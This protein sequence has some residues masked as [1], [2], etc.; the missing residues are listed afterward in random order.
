M[1]KPLLIAL[2]V[3][4]TACGGRNSEPY[5][6][7][8]NA[9]TYHNGVYPRFADE[10]PF[11]WQGI[12]PGRYPIHGIDISKYQ[13]DVEWLSVRRSGVSFAYIK[14][15]EGGDH[16]D[17]KFTQNWQNAAR[18]NVLRGAYHFYY[19]CRTAAEQAKWFIEN[20]PRDRTALPPVLDIEWN[21]QSRNC[22]G[23]PPAHHIRN[24][25][26][27]FVS[28]LTAHYGRRPL[29]YTTVDFY[30]ENDIGRVQGADFWLRSVAAHPSKAYPGQRWTLWQYTGTGNVPGIKGKVDL[31][32]FAGSPEAWNTWVSYLRQ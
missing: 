12:R 16:L 30:A 8:Q 11:D 26:T 32:A 7:P 10:D 28:I 24:E 14:A 3:V 15:T 18:A 29:I 13:G 23:K 22:P 27:R 21:H 17:E 20:V 9:P 4:L 25:M 31:N 1:Y 5:E 6:Q 2:M 19:F